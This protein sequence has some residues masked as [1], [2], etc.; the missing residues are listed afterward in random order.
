[1]SQVSSIYHVSTFE[2]LLHCLLY[3]PKGKCASTSLQH[4]AS[5]LTFVTSSLVSLFKTSFELLA[6]QWFSMCSFPRWRRKTSTD[7]E[8]IQRLVKTGSC[9]LKGSPPSNVLGIF[10]VVV[11]VVVCL[12]VFGF[13]SW[14][15]CPITS[16][17]LYWNYFI[18]VF[19]I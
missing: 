12:F 15:Q 14:D 8:S 11:V 18:V 16:K 4:M 5:S 10:V 3:S 9:S 1:M 2:F 7:S 13:F 6:I 19:G 17:L